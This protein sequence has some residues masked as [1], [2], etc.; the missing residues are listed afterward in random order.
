MSDLSRPRHAQRDDGDLTV[1]LPAVVPAAEVDIALPPRAASSVHPVAAMAGL[2]IAACWILVVNHSTNVLIGVATGGVIGLVAVLFWA[3][4]RDGEIEAN[5]ARIA[6]DIHN[7]RNNVANAQANLSA[8]VHDHNQQTLRLTSDNGALRKQ[9]ESTAA[10]FEGARVWYL[11]QLNAVLSSIP[12]DTSAYA[13]LART[14]VGTDDPVARAILQLKAYVE[15]RVW[16]AAPGA[17]SQEVDLAG[18][19]AVLVDIGYRCQDIAHQAIDNIDTLIRHVAD[20]D[21]LAP[22]FEIDHL[23]TRVRRLSENLILIGGPPP[24][25]WRDACSLSTVFRSAK[26]EIQQYRRVDVTN[27]LTAAVHGH[28]VV[29]LVHLL[30]ELLENAASFSKPD[31]RVS[32]SARLVTAGVA[33]SIQDEGIGMDVP[34]LD[35]TNDMLRTETSIERLLRDARLAGLWIVS[36]LA[37]SYEI[38]V[39]LAPNIFGGVTAAVVLPHS[40]LTGM[41]TEP[42]VT[43]NTAELAEL[44]AEPTTTTAPPTAPPTSST[45]AAAA[46]PAP[47]GSVRTTAGPP[48]PAATGRYPV[49]DRNGGAPIENGRIDSGRIDTGRLD[50][51]RR[52]AP[53]VGPQWP[54]D[55]GT[56]SGSLAATPGPQQREAFTP[57]PDD[58]LPPLPVRPTGKRSMAPAL[59]RTPNKSTD[60]VHDSPDAADV[61]AG[62]LATTQQVRGDVP[63]R[64][65]TPHDVPGDAQGETTP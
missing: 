15:S 17:E 33:I 61:M 63:F 34:S 4:R 35:D 1:A 11:D 65:S 5:R 46:Q 56:T 45:A 7:L 23:I 38:R 14:D 18:S 19:L 13:A 62:F 30:A 37:R 43:A 60:V 50:D 12:V 2:A 10:A 36:H 24:R 22:L 40:L 42:S 32:L 55:E 8:T 44:A 51:R 64:P 48:A 49:A 6:Q 21:V 3:R 39:Q 54:S 29:P 41:P 9:L 58:D 25:Q 47:G 28:V 31:T 16:L 52:P 59:R 20:P 26:A 27:Q 53:P 57:P